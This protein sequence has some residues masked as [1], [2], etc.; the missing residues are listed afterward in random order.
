MTFVNPFEGSRELF[1]LRP[2]TEEAVAMGVIEG[3]YGESRLT[4]YEGHSFG[5]RG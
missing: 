4:T 3:N 5:W 2:G 1:W